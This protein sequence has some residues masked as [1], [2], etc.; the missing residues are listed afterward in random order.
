M[1]IPTKAL[2][3]GGGKGK[4]LERKRVGFRGEKMGPG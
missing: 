3:G 1:P 4:N 2:G